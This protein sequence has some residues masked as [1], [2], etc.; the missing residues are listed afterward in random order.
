MSKLSYVISNFAI[1]TLPVL[2]VTKAPVNLFTTLLVNA[3][4][5]RINTNSFLCADN[6]DLTHVYNKDEKLLN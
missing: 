4:K 3:M 5:I 6:V 1:T 2:I